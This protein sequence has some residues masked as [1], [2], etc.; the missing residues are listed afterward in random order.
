MPCRWRTC[1]QQQQ[2][3]QQQQQVSVTAQPLAEAA[4]WWQT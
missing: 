2:Q 4:L 1:K 3:Q